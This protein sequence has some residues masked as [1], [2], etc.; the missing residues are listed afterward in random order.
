MIAGVN[1]LVMTAVDQGNLS[2]MRGVIG[3]ATSNL[4]QLV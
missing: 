1:T 2:L 3:R 4:D